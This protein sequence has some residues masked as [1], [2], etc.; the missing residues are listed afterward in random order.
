VPKFTG[1]IITEIE[2]GSAADEARLQAGDIILQVNRVTV[3]SL[4]NYR[5]EI[6]KAADKKSVTL[7]IKRGNSNFFVALRME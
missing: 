5:K 6:A 3:K 7:L 2:P 4:E 1:V